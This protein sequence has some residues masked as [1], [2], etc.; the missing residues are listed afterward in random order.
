M[1]EGRDGTKEEWEESYD[2]PCST[3]GAAPCFTLYLGLP[4]CHKCVE[5]LGGYEETDPLSWA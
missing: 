1:S 5:D 4:L 3:C 2:A